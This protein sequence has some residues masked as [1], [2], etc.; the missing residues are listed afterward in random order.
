MDGWPSEGALRNSHL[1]ELVDGRLEFFL[2]VADA[3]VVR[4]AAD[5]PYIPS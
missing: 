3:V 4:S 5:L 1:V 2:H